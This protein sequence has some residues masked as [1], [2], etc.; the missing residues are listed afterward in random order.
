MSTL[1][2]KERLPKALVVF[3][4]VARQFGISHFTKETLRVVHEIRAS[5]NYVP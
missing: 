2:N 4:V 1:P 3:T 5:G